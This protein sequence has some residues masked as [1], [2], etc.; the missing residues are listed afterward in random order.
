MRN[1]GISINWVF[2]ILCLAGMLTACT[3]D[4]VG[5][6]EDTIK[7]SE[8]EV[9]VP[10]SQSSYLIT[11]Q[12][13]FWWISELYLAGNQIDYSS[14][15]TSRGDFLIDNPEFSIERDNSTQIN[16]QLNTNTTGVQ[17]EL[18]IYLQAGNYGDRIRVVQA[19]Q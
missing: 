4:E 9:Q 7:F 1:F 18:L 12:G 3:N 11:T 6:G 10:A 2:S 15:D 8:K 14:V 5:F 17:R 13:T 16:I 19:G